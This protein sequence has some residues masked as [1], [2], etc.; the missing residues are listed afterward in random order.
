MLSEK[1]VAVIAA[2]PYQP[3]AEWEVNILPFGSIFWKDEMPAIVDLFDRPEDMAIIH[4]MFGIRLK[5]WDGVAL[6][7]QDQQLWNAVKRQVPQCR[8]P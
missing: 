7:A 2:L 6:E 5:I 4:A 1:I 8:E 3:D